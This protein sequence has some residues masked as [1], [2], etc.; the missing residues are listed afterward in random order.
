MASIKIY[1]Q[2]TPVSFSTG[3]NADSTNAILVSE[4]F[5]LTSLM[6]T[7]TLHPDGFDLIFKDETAIQDFIS[8]YFQTINAA[9]GIVVNAEGKLLFIFRRGKWDLPKGKMEVNENEEF[10]A[11]REI[12]E[13]TGVQNLKL[14]Q[15]LIDTFH[16]YPE[17]DQMVLKI[18]HWFLFS[19][20]DAQITTPQIEE[21]I[22]EVRWFGKDELDLPLSNSYQNILLV[23]SSYL[24][25]I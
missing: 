22:T 16:V 6:N 15:K 21:D 4:A 20:D 9:G 12:E 14:H 25:T 8:T 19:I 2:D 24:Q 13:E 11:Q 23:V 17:I 3:V 1:V 7:V 18:S 5:S 10:C